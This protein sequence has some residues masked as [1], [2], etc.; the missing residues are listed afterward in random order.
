MSIEQATLASTQFDEGRPHPRGFPCQAGK[1]TDEAELGLMESTSGELVAGGSYDTD[2]R[3]A[4]SVPR[5]LRPSGSRSKVV[6]AQCEAAHGA[7]TRPLTRSEVVELVE[8]A[9]RD[10][11]AGKV[12]VSISCCSSWLLSNLFQFHQHSRS[13]LKLKHYIT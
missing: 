13:F 3:L 7:V 4:W 9:A 1:S 11:A 8:A 10:E 6:Q 2:G 12:L 5:G